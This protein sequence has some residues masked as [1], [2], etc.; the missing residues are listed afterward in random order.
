VEY[1]RIEISWPLAD[2]GSVGSPANW[3]ITKIDPFV[4]STIEM[5]ASEYGPEAAA[6]LVWGLDL[7]KRLDGALAPFDGHGSDS[8]TGLGMRDIGLR[9][10]NVARLPEAFEAVVAVLA[11][12]PV[13]PDSATI[14]A[15]LEREDEEGDEEFAAE[16]DEADREVSSAVLGD[17]R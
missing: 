1:G 2:A 6:K 3:L 16:G 13:I 5:M 17:R 14:S 12:D 7:S 4:D 11:A 10:G 8:G 15:Y 9:V